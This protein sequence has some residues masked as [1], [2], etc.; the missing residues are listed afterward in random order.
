MTTNLL[1]E[2]VTQATVERIK[3]ILGD[4]FKVEPLRDGEGV[5]AYWLEFDGQDKAIACTGS[6]E[7]M[8]TQLADA[9][10]EI[11]AF[12]LAAAERLDAAAFA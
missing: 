9:L 10:R 1:N 7:P 6:P 8:E 12:Y 5:S 4:E 11:A 2:S 3:T